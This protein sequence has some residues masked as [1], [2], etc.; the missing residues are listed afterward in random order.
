MSAIVDELRLE[1][2]ERLDQAR[3]QLLFTPRL[4]AADP[5]ETLRAALPWTDVVQVRI[6][7]EPG[8]GTAPARE[9]WEWTRRV[10]A[11]VSDAGEGT[12]VVVNDR[13]DVA[14]SLASEGCAGVHLGQDDA[15]VEIARRFLG[16]S[17]VL[18]LSTHDASQIGLAA[19]T[20]DLDTLGFGPIHATATKGYRRGVGAEAAWIAQA[21]T[22]LPVFPI[23]GIDATNA[24][25]LDTVGRA[26]VSSAILGAE[27]PGR[28]AETIYTLLAGESGTP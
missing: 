14:A 26:A 9:T 3:L 5:L 8:R 20:D 12:L 28:A 27:D 4:C 15:P 7:P 21:A 13:V 10:L 22:S 19:T 11:L 18:G 24:S 25:E 16:A 17:A 6:E 23:G 2:R 1:R